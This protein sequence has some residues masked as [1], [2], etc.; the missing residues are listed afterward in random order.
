MVKQWML[1]YPIKG[2]WFYITDGLKVG[3]VVQCAGEYLVSHHIKVNSF[4]GNKPINLVLNNRRD[5]TEFWWYLKE[6]IGTNRK[7]KLRLFVKER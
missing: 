3:V 1:V 2:K 4:Y 7:V 6:S 5:I